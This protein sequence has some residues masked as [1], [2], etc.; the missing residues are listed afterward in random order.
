MF[1]KENYN[2][3]AI[4]KNS[5][6]KTNSITYILKYDKFVLTNITLNNIRTNRKTL[7]SWA[8]GSSTK[9]TNFLKNKLFLECQD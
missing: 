7:Q 3:F 5:K 2:S 9:I 8:A 6:N 1:L 4:I